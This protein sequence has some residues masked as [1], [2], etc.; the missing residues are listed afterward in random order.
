MKNIVLFILSGFFACTIKAQSVVLK[1]D[2]VFVN[3]KLYTLFIPVRSS[4]NVDAF[5]S[6]TG[7]L[8]IEAHN[9]HIN[10]K[11]KPGYVVTFLNDQQQCMIVKDGRFPLSFIKGVV[12]YDLIKNGTA[13]NEERELKFIKDHPMPDGYTDVDRLI[14]Y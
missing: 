1:N 10:V 7:E 6:F 5:F 13:V 3:K 9:G 14:E 11:G 8:L 4:R 12:Q 2:S